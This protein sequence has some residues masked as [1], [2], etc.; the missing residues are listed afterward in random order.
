[1]SECPDC[2]ETG[3]DYDGDG[4]PFPCR[5]WRHRCRPSL[6][7]IADCLNR[8]VEPPRP[9]MLPEPREERNR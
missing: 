6:E 1:M 4:Q 5:N 2:D 8:G 3:V 9:Y 7:E